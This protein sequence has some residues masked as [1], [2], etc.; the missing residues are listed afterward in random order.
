MPEVRIISTNSKVIHS[1][2]R[3][4]EHR[5][6]WI[7]ITDLCRRTTNDKIFI[8]VNP[9]GSQK[10]SS[11]FGQEFDFPEHIR[12]RHQPTVNILHLQIAHSPDFV[13]YQCLHSHTSKRIVGEEAE[14]SCFGKQLTNKLEVLLNIEIL[15]HTSNNIEIM[16]VSPQIIRRRLPCMVIHFIIRN[17]DKISSTSPNDNR[18]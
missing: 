4:R 15:Q 7:S 13:F 12:I 11:S 17:S 1:C 2:T 5:D 18:Q 6:I 9:P 8:A 16:T 14:L 10:K 3:K